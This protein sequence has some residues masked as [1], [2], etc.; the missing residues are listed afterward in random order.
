MINFLSFSLSSYKTLCGFVVRERSSVPAEP[1][2]ILPAGWQ[3]WSCRALL[4]L[5]W[6]PLHG[7]LRRGATQM[8]CEFILQPPRHNRKLISMKRWSLSPNLF[9]QG[10]GIG[11]RAGSLYSAAQVGLR[12][13]CCQKKSSLAPLLHILCLPCA[14]VSKLTV[15]C[16]ASQGKNQYFDQPS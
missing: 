11:S 5:S 3:W 8:C 7:A 6:A 9:C 4:P 13:L 15:L 16:S 10:T 1:L 14:G 12:G 2:S